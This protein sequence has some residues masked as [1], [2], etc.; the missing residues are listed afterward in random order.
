MIIGKIIFICTG[1]TCRSVMAE[2]MFI[3]RIKNTGLKDVVVDSAGTHA[4]PY[5]AIV[6]DL[7][8]VMDENSVDYAGHIPQMIDENIM[9]SSDLVIVM[10]KD[11]KE[12]ISR[13]FPAYKDKVFLLTEYADDDNKNKDII[14]P[15]GMSVE[16]Y[17]NV[18]K[19]IAENLDKLKEKLDEKSQKN[20]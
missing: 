3:K 8:T 2:K 17:R 7:K 14:D 9:K 12:E 11:H 4:M 6:G 16:T 10:T 15:I 18:Y 20:R 1:N 19:Q 5:Y 13:R